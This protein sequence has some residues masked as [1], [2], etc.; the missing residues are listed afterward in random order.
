MLTSCF[1]THLVTALASLLPSASPMQLDGTSHVDLLVLGLGWTGSF[2]LPHLATHHKDLTVAATTRDG[3]DGTLQWAWDPERDGK[4]QY[5]SLPRAK[6]VVVVFPLKGEGYSARLVRGYEE[7]VGQR[8]RWIQLGSTG[9]FDGGP[10]LA[11]LSVKAND[12]EKPAAAPKFEWTT[13]HS[14]Y[15]RK[16]LRAIAEDE[17]LSQ[18]SDTVVLNLVGLWGGSRN[19]ANWF[20]RIAPTPEALE[21]KGSLHLLHGIDLA[22]AIIAVHLAP[23]LPS[24]SSTS[25]SAPDSPRAGTGQRWIVSDL[26]VLDWW[27]LASAHP[28]A[29]PPPSTTAA[30][31]ERSPDRALWVQDFMRKH[32]VRALPRTPHELGRAIDAREFWEAFGLMPVRGRW[33][34]ARA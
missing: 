11:S 33:E 32:G 7:S 6:T 28:L 24:S 9:I 20:A 22:R 31:G 1:P 2:L 23:T 12:A 3:R 19:P 8:V 16:N 26:R 14:P 10:T 18:H 15:D 5:A 30:G 13:R 27:D 21:G 25:T 17:L 34:E 29:G 4:D